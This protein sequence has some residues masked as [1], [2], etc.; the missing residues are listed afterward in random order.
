MR[1]SEIRIRH[2]IE[3][4]RA[5]NIIVTARSF[6]A[7]AQSL[8]DPNAFREIL[9]NMRVYDE[10]LSNMFEE[11]SSDVF[12]EFKEIQDELNISFSEQI[13]NEGNALQQFI[14]GEINEIEEQIK[15]THNIKTLENILG[16]HPA[17]VELMTLLKQPFILQNIAKEKKLSPA[18][19]QNRLFKAVENRKLEIVGEQERAIAQENAAKAQLVQMIKDSI[20]FLSLIHI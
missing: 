10:E 11:N 12:S 13:V 8:D 18:A 20:D 6:R 14:A 7:K 4:L 5:K 19:I 3:D 17:S 1:P 16:T 15:K 9:N 2:L